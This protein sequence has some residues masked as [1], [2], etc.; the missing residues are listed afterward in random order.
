MLRASC[1]QLNVA[2]WFTFLGVFLV[3]SAPGIAAAQKSA[4]KAQSRPRSDSIPST[5][6]LEAATAPIRVARSVLLPRYHEAVV[7]AEREG[8]KHPGSPDTTMADRRCVDADLYTDAR[9]LGISRSGDFTAGTFSA[10]AAVWRHGGGKLWFTPRLVDTAA[11]LV[12]RARRLDATA[13]PFEYRKRRLARAVGTDDLFYAT[14][15][16][17]PAPGV[18]LLIATAGPNWGCFLFSFQ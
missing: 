6:W 12:V 10:Y 3:L 8:S 11:T 9:G 17:L 7:A 14:T 15:I 13:A 1:G 18:W 16:R 2:I 4:V 5:R